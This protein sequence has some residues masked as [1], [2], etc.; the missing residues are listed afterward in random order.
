MKSNAHV[1]SF[2]RALASTLLDFKD[3]VEKGDKSGA[4]LEYAFALG[5]IGGATLSGAIGKDEGGVLIT[6]RRNFRHPRSTPS[7]KASKS[8]TLPP[9]PKV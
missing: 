8:S 6:N 9:S 5:L 7:S 3:L 1:K 4:N 2:S